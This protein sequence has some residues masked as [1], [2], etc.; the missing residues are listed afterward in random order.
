MEGLI[1]VTTGA[2]QRIDEVT[3][4]DSPYLR[5]ALRGGGCSGFE[6][7]YS[8]ESN[9]QE[10]D[11]VFGNLVVDFMTLGYL[12]GATLDFKNDLMGSMF[13]ITSPKITQSCGCGASVN[14]S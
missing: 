2:K 1:T 10:T 11:F 8:L 7:Q 9:P 12:D 6:Y 4:D 5:V 13:I 14:F 3:E